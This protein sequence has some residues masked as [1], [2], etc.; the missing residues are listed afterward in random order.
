MAK[1]WLPI[2]ESTTGRET[3]LYIP[4]ASHMDG[5]QLRE[6]I[7]KQTEQIRAEARKAGPVPQ[8]RYSKKEVAGALRDFQARLERKRNG[9]GNP[10]YF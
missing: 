2:K 10:R 1:F 5:G 9:T 4:G 6:I 8:R 7:A 3:I